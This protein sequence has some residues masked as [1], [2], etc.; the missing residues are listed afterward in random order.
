MRVDQARED[1]LAAQVDH[2]GPR[3]ALTFQH[4]GARAGRRDTPALYRD[5][6]YDMER[7]VH[8]NDFAVVQNQV[9]IRC[10]GGEA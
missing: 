5:R 1:R 6:L 2:P 9:R 8:G 7:R 10:Q 4:V 3:S